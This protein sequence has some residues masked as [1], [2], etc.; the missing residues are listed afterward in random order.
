MY[1]QYEVWWMDSLVACG[2]TEC[3]YCFDWV[4]LSLFNNLFIS[5]TLDSQID[6]CPFLLAAKLIHDYDANIC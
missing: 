5:L 4:I 6:S 3:H 2:Y 1:G